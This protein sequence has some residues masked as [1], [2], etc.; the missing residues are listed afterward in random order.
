[1]RKFREAKGFT[2]IELLVVMGLIAILAAIAVPNVVNYLRA[3]EERAWQSDQKII[4]AAVEAYYS[5]PDNVRYQ[6]M[7]QYPIYGRDADDPTINADPGSKNW[8]ATYGDNPERGTKGGVKPIWDDD[9][10]DGRRAASIA[11]EGWDRTSISYRG[12]T[13]YFSS[14]NYIID[15]AELVPDYLKEVPASASPDNHSSGTGSYTWYLDSD[16]KVQSLLYEFP[17]SDNAGFISGVWP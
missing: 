12:K 5:A 9:D 11:E 6:G 10:G 3:G 14:G 7:R 1:M 4:Q 8:A 17:I 16:G 13:Y 15:M 2:L